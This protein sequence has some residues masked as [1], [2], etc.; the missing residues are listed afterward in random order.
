MEGKALVE[1]ALERTSKLLEL[2]ADP[3]L[4]GPAAA[5][6]QDDRGGREP[7][8]VRVLYP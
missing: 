3:G 2:P 4:P 1:N 5:L 8:Q 7:G 6:I